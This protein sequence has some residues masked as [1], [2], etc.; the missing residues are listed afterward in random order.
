MNMFSST[1]IVADVAPTPATTAPF[2]VG[3]TL[4]W[5]TGGQ[6]GTLLV[7]AV[8]GMAFA[9]DQ[10][11]A[12]SGA[13]VTQRDG[14]VKDGKVFLYN[15]KWNETW[16]GTYSNGMVIGRINNFYTFQITE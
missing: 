3:K 8:N 12:R 11:N 13:G 4:K 14:E 16:V 2:F 6:N 7:T 5:A 1:L 10:K 9:V 15:R